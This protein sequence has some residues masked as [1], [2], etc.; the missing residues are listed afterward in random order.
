MIL[1]SISMVKPEG[2]DLENSGNRIKA[3][4]DGMVLE[5]KAKTMFQGKKHLKFSRV[6]AEL[7][8]MLKHYKSIKK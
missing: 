7:G 5:T 8:K 6:W 1:E 3:Q 4:Q 2:Y